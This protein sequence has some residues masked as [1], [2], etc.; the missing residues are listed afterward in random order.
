MGKNIEQVLSTTII[1]IFDVKKILLQ[2]IAHQ[3]TI[4]HNLKVT[5]NKCPRRLPNPPPNNGPSLRQTTL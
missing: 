3:K 2:T 4:I 1:L 5:K